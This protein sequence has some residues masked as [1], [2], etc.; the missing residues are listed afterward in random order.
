MAA[1]GDSLRVAY[2][3]LRDP[4]YSETF[5]TSEIEAVR[6]VGA[7]VEVF[8]ARQGSRAAE[9]RQIV[10]A[11][12]RHPFRTLADVRALGMSYLPR[13]VLASAHAARLAGPIAAFAPDV[14]HAHFVNLPTAVAALVGRR[15]GVPSTA[16][17][18]AADFLLDRNGSALDRRLRLL[19]HLFVISEATAGQLTERGASLSAIPHGV[20]RAAFDGEIVE[21]QPRRTG[22]V[23]RLVTVARLVEKKGVDTALDAVAQ[24]TR[25][26][27]PVRYDIYGDGPLRT[28]LEERARALALSDVVT[29]HGAVSHRV[30]TEALVSADVAVLPCRRAADG[31][32]DG[33]PVFLMEAASRGIPV[34][35]TAVSGIPELIGPAGGWQV[36]P[37]DPDAL[38]DAVQQLVSRPDEGHRRARILAAR[39]R[40]E[41]SPALQAR[42]LLAVWGR[43]A[44]PGSHAP[45][46]FPAGAAAADTTNSGAASAPG[47][48]ADRRAVASEEAGTRWT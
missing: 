9:L 36:P 35:T 18:H 31:D 13:A 4:S 23:T 21:R 47:V 46:P 25:A 44:R 16:M 26:G 10:G 3:L 48:A 1:P 37:N 19:N 24:L 5:I 27:V 22:D 6:A 32:L 34:V 40:D 33:I 42:R 8:V 28:T 29:F 7:T 41:F 45:E 17:A 39:L 2:V 15:T 20:V 14:L 12:L 30:A 43:L 11:V 38:A